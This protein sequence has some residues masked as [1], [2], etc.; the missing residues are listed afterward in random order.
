MA[1]FN[2]GWKKKNVFILSASNLKQIHR[3]LMHGMNHNESNQNGLTHI[4][5]LLAIK[6]EKGTY[7]ACVRFGTLG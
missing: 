1:M 2:E 6:H 4:H 7:L 3:V 5:K